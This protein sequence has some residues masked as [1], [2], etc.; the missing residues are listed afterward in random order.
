MMFVMDGGSEDL[1]HQYNV[2]FLVQSDIM[3]IG[4]Q[5][6]LICWFSQTYRAWGYQFL[7]FPTSVKP[8]VHRV[9]I[10]MGFMN[11]T[12]FR[13]Q[14][15]ILFVGYIFC[16]DFMNLT[17]FRDQSNLLSIGYMYQ[18]SWVSGI[19]QT[20]CLWGTHFCIF[21]GSVKRVFF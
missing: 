3:F 13:D 9:L 10:F 18:F 6:L 19:S 4:Y 11:L 21:H 7:G 2:D 15:N 14:S 12:D 5:F 16:V 1:W 20:Y 8:I 17:D